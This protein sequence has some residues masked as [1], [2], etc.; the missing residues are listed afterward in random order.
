MVQRVGIDFGTT[1]S[2]ISVVTSKEKI[3]S[4]TDFN[5]PHPSVVR[6]EG[7]QII[8]GKKARDKLEQRSIGVMGNTIRGFKKLISS[9]VVNVEGRLMTPVEVIG[10][11]IRYLV[12]HA[13]ESDEGQFSDLTRAVV[14]IPVALDGRGRKALREALLI[15]GVQVD[16][17]VHEPLAAL[18][19]YF[20]DQENFEETIRSHDGCLIL[21]FDWGGGTLDGSV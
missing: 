7:D 1:N 20:R 8:C 12:S 10:D 13:Q 3:L 15:A 16:M 2:L 9:E 21:V 14:T 19:G 6:Y 4:F 17:F 5:R 11:Y 18:Y